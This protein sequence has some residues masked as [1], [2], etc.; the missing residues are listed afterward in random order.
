[1]SDPD[2]IVSV[3]GYLILLEGRILAWKSRGQ[4]SITLSS[5]EVEYVAASETCQEM[6]AILQ[7]TEFLDIKIK[8][9]MRVKIDTWPTTKILNGR[10]HHVKICYHFVHQLIKDGTVLV[11]FVCSKK[12]RQTHGQRIWMQI[13]FHKQVDSYVTEFPANRKVVGEP[14]FVGYY[15]ADLCVKE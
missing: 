12:T 3:T 11:G 4:K 1:M 15:L 9:P 13:F 5:T 10:T 2:K 7:I 14:V 8:Y 6:I